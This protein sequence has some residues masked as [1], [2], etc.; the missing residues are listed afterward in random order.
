MAAPLDWPYSN[1]AE[2]VGARE[3]VLVER[4]FVTDHFGTARDYEI[5]VLDYLRTRRLPDEL[6]AYL[7]TI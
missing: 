5:F 6:R 1:Y 3:G 7:E 4:A 2:W